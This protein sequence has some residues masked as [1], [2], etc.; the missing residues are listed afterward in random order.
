MVTAFTL[1][2]LMTKPAQR[3]GVPVKMLRGNRKL[4]PAF[5]TLAAKQPF[6]FCLFHLGSKAPIRLQD[7]GTRDK[8]TPLM[9]VPFRVSAFHVEDASLLA[10]D[11]RVLSLAKP[12]D[13]AVRPPADVTLLLP[14]R[15]IDARRP[16]QRPFKA[17]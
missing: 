11:G 3:F 5:L 9:V 14:L 6:E 10:V 15:G 8:T 4:S 12:G 1:F 7:D 13:G 2:A 17:G 16:L